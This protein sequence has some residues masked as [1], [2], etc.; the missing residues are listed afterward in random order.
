MLQPCMH[1][2]VATHPTAPNFLCCSEATIIRRAQ[3]ATLSSSTT[4]I[5]PTPTPTRLRERDTRRAQTT[6][7]HQRCCSHCLDHVFS[8]LALVQYDG[9]ARRLVPLL[10]SRGSIHA[11][12]APS[13]TPWLQQPALG[14]STKRYHSC[15][16]VGPCFRTRTNTDDDN[17]RHQID[18]GENSSCC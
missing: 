6:T 8:P 1:S 4:H 9:L 3:S 5:R 13:L 14:A 11:R 12:L 2:T 15:D 10:P 18:S 16:G 17:N 7:R